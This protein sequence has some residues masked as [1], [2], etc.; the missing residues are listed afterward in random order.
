MWAFLTLEYK[1]PVENFPLLRAAPA[2]G[3]VHGLSIPLIHSGYSLTQYRWAPDKA[4]LMNYLSP[5]GQAYDKDL[6]RGRNGLF[7]QATQWI[8]FSWTEGFITLPQAH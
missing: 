5:K 7:L 3:W 2:S 4:E 8:N 1:I 6:E